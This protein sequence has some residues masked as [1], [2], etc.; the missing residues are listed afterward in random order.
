MSNRF[1][2]AVIDDVSSR[3]INDVLEASLLDLFESAI[4]TVATTLVREA[5]FDISDFALTKERG[6][7]GFA[8]LVSRIR[9]DSRNEWC[10]KFQRGDQRLDVIGHLE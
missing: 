1:K 2:K 4:K 6:C 10:G 8:L 5:N 9:A 3:S 7:E